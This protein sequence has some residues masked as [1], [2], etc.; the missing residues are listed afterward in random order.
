LEEHSIDES[1]RVV[2]RND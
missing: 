1:D 2:L